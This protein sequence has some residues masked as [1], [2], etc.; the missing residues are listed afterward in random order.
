MWCYI[1]FKRYHKLYTK[2]MYGC[3][4]HDRMFINNCILISSASKI[5]L[6]SNNG[7]V[8]HPNSIKIRWSQTA[9]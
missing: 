5:K 1:I 2:S 4:T 9:S 7:K 6:V 8:I 3:G